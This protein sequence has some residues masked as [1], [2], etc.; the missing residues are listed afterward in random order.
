MQ[1][2]CMCA[3]CNE[4]LSSVLLIFTVQQERSKEEERQKAAEEAQSR[5]EEERQNMERK[6]KQI[7]Q[8]KEEQM[9]VDAERAALEQATVMTFRYN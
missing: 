4:T 5:E 8:E 9:K 6:M 1:P 2:L 3:R 7:Q